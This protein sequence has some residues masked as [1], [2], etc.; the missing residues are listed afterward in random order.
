M[1]DL[2]FERA[3]FG[4]GPAGTTC[5]G[6]HQPIAGDY[7]DVNGQP[8]CPAC[9]ASLLQAHG[10]EPGGP[11]F[12]RAFVAGTGAGAVGSALYYVVAAISGYQL[13]IIAIAV[14]FLVGKAVR[15]GTGGRGGLTFQLLAVALTYVAIAFSD[16]PFILASAPEGRV[17]GVDDVVPLTTYLI[18]QPIRQA[19]EQPIGVVIM[20]IGLWEAWKMN[21]PVRL[22]ITGPFHAAPPPPPVPPIPTAAS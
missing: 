13:S 7:F 17:I 3:E 20:A 19:G 4:G 15:W 12:F 21:T 16:L 22:A 8:F 14:G 2:Q 1:T 18:G 9:K 11:A 10:A 6:C 5:T